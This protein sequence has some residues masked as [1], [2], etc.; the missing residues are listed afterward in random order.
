MYGDKAILVHG[1]LF[2]CTVLVTQ[3]TV[4]A[5]R[6]YK[7]NIVKLKQLEAKMKISLLCTKITRKIEQNLALVPQNMI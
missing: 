2:Y 6:D 7:Q 1:M 5:L 3:K 4:L